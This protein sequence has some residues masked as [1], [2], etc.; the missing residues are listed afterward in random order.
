MLDIDRKYLLNDAQLLDFIARGYHL[1]EPVE[2]EFPAGFHEAISAE[3]SNFKSNPGNSIYERVP[4]LQKIYNSPRVRGALLSIL[5]HDMEMD[6]HRHLHTVPPGKLV[7]QTWHQDGTN[8]RHHQTWVCLA[9][10]YPQD[11]TPEM[12][13]TAILPGTHFRNAPTDQ[14]ANYTNIKGTVYLTVKAGTVA[15]THFDLWHAATLNRSKTPRH[16]L[17]FL[18]N[19]KSEPKFGKPSWNHDAVTGRETLREKV[20]SW[21]GPINHYCSDYYKEWELRAEMW[22]WYHGIQTPVP[23]GGFRTLLS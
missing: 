13:P 2:G 23:A 7:S 22:N 20:P 21:V 1:V 14:M 15:I 18:F 4:A 17:K 11:V 5:G 10:Y 6:E 12:G 9:M 16:M 8:V 3:C 19:R